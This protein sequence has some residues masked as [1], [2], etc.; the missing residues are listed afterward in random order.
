[1]LYY[2]MSLYITITLTGLF[3]WKWNRYISVS[4][5]VAF[6]LMPII[7][8]GY[9][10]VAVAE[11]YTE[12]ILANGLCYLCSSFLQLAIMV[13][14]FSFCRVKLPRLLSVPLFV[15]N[16]FLGSMALTTHHNHLLYEDSWLVRENGLSYIGKVYG[17]LHTVFYIMIVFYMA[18]DVGVLI[19]GFTRRDVSKKNAMILA[20]VYLINIVSFFGTKLFDLSVEMQPAAYILT[21][22]VM[23]ILSARLKMYSVTEMA[24]DTITDEGKTGFFAF[25]MSRHYLGCSVPALSCLPELAEMYIDEPLRRGEP[26]FDTI[27][28]WLDL[29]DMNNKPSEFDLERGG[30]SYKIG[31]NYTLIGGKKKGYQISIYDNTDERRYIHLLQDARQSAEAV[32]QAKGDF[33]AHMSHEIRTPINAILGMDEMILRESRDEQTLRYAEDIRKAGNT[34]LGLINDILDFSKIEAGKTEIIPVD[35]Q[36]SSVLNDLSSMIEP[37]VSEKGLS[38][39]VKVDPSIPE[40]LRGDE[41]RIKQIVMNLLTNAVKYT[42]QGTVTLSAEHERNGDDVYLTIHVR[43][44]GVG[45]KKEDI[46]KLFIA[47]ERIEEERN[48]SIEGT[49]LGITITQRLLRL[50]GSR[51]E[52]DSV[53]GEGSDFWFTLKQK[54][55]KNTPI[56]DFSAAA[57]KSD[58]SRREYHESFTAP[59]AW[60][61]VVDDT[62]MNLVVFRNL[63]K[64][65]KMHI[66]TALGG[67]AA[68]HLA[69]QYKYD[70]IF[71]DHRMPDKD[72]IETLQELRTD[73][74]G[75]NRD[76]PAVCLTANAIS[77]MREFYISSGF[78][79]YLT[80]PIDPVRLE[81]MI[82]ELLPD[83]LVHTA[84]TEDENGGADISEL[85]DIYLDDIARMSAEI[86]K[87]YNNGDWTNYT[88]KVH[89]LKSTSRL[90]GEQNIG[91]LAE[92]LE[93][94]GDSGDTAFIH[95]HNAE[96]LEMYR[97][98]PEKYGRGAAA[99]AKPDD[100]KPEATEAMMLDAFEDMRAAADNF[101]YDVLCEVLDELNDY[102]IPESFAGK[103]QAV[104]AAADSVDWGTLKQLLQ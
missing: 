66:D 7:N 28:K 57:G 34:L 92:Q 43:D 4:Y 64:K 23:I 32:S 73:S 25:D 75:L 40:Y 71:L 61:L 44:T 95:A 101:D 78:C 80:K 70:L 56:G 50:M 51:L 67:D 72:G 76:T 74:G 45:I 59:E 102:R 9:L 100:N 84:I 104:T 24:V 88:I 2:Q 91:A 94:A 31:V 69:E 54:M 68:I 85:L 52:V 3:L 30:I 33:L 86:E 82:V 77:G 5:A 47:F 37:R 42:K 20:V 13:Y 81:T 90:V 26:C 18:V 63:L 53:Y 97:E 89:A 49:G 19:Y 41:I 21:Q 22:I 1:M 103:M 87:L 55:V 83:A 8:V 10:R 29:T 96:L 38:F 14:V 62:E 36:L 35:Y 65:T 60:V 39:T 58:S 46:D 93:K 11:S 12:A 48:R 17:P 79:E 15:L 6:L 98:V 99:D 27:H 16:S